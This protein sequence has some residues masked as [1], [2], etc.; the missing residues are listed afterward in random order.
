MLDAE[1][2]AIALGLGQLVGIG[3][4]TFIFPVFESLL[5]VTDNLTTMNHYT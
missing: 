2:I 4:L 1:T 5:K 3:G